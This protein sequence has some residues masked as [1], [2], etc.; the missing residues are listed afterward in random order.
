MCVCVL[1]C[2]YVCTCWCPPGATGAGAVRKRGKVAVKAE[3]RTPTKKGKAAAAEVTAK[4][5]LIV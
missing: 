3:P 5:G 4:L 1:C 2:S